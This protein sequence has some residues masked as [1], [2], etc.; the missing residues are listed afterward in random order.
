MLYKSE[1]FNKFMKHIVNVE[2]VCYTYPC[3]NNFYGGIIG[4]MM[5]RKNTICKG[6]ILRISNKI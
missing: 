2:K 3:D 4:K 6:K 5:R 1:T